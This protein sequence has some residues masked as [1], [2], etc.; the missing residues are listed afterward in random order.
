LIIQQDD[1]L[2]F[3]KLGCNDVLDLALFAPRRY[4]D[5]FLSK[6]LVENSEVVTLFT[7]QS[8]PM[9]VKNK[10]MKVRGFL[11]DFEKS[12][13]AVFFNYQNYHRTIFKI[14]TPVYIRGVYKSSPFLPQILQPKILNKIDVIDVKYPQK[15]IQNRSIISL[16]DR[17]LDAKNL[18]EAGL[19]DSVIEQILEL[20]HPKE[21]HFS[22]PLCD[23]KKLEAL[24][25]VE[26]YTHLLRL[27]KK[28]SDYPSKGVLSGNLDRFID[29]LPFKLTDAQLEAIN[30]IRSDLKS[31]IA[32]KRVVVG[33]VGC[34]KTLVILA[35]VVL[36][37]PKRAVLMAPTTILA[38]QIYE[39][40]KK[41]LPK[42]IEIKLISSNSNKK[43]VESNGDFV[44]GTHA[45]LYR[46]L[47]DFDLVMVDEQHRFG[48]NQRNELYKNL[49]IG[50]QRAHF[51]QFSATP[52]PR[53]MAMIDSAMVDFSFIKELP[54]KR[55]VVTKVI[56]K[57]HFKEL[58]EH[59][60]GEIERGFQTI[61]VYPLV[62]ES[63][64][65]D[66]LSIAEG[67]AFWNNRFDGVYVTHGKD[68]EKETILKEFRENGKI[69]LT[70]TVIEVG[71]SLPKLGTIVVVG[72]ERMGLATL[73][74]LRGRVGRYGDIGHC[75]LYTNKLEN[76]RLEE[77]S[78]IESG[79]EIAELDLKYR[80]SGDLT[81][82]KIQSG[83]SF[84]YFDM[85]ED[86]EILK[87][88]KRDLFG[89]D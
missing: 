47:G 70:T 34:G 40:A 21:S 24:K 42:E 11:D 26:I 55:N 31:S 84:R 20:H 74:Q 19:K 43:D 69:L 58:L 23:S 30:E 63:E 22:D 2:K 16:M 14:D 59:I 28:R 67:E 54:F 49:H 17:Y 32:S 52:I 3:K 9:L 77:F 66:Y 62:E 12:C 27:K 36:A 5:N 25:Y 41:F 51:L 61:I 68:K 73:H 79:F 8:A 10:I 75:F 13:E 71:I 45:L 18:K 86:I 87:T 64:N 48:T 83:K 37:Y 60:R 46:D 78:A 82:G 85:A 50:E 65:F 89:E 57:H 6:N 80:N 72:A 1:V 44:I 29:S 15:N 38:S 76:K 35:S 4:D 39:E 88:A 81:G 7:P 56:S 33:D 53:T